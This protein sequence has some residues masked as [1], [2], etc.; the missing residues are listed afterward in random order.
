M[1]IMGTLLRHGSEEQKKKCLPRISKGELR[2]QSFAITEPEAGIDT[3]R[4]QTSAVRNQNGYVINGHKNLYFQTA[5]FRISCC[6]LRELLH[7]KASK[8]RPTD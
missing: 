1:Y 2:L 5:A 7:M 6:F 4:I 8:E 3:S